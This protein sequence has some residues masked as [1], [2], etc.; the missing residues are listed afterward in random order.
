MIL[1][2]QHVHATDADDYQQDAR[3]NVRVLKRP[4]VEQ[5]TGIS[6]SLIYELVKAGTFPRPVKLTPNRVGWLEHEVFA[7]VQARAA[8]RQAA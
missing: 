8:R 5:V 3:Q 4:A 1:N 2:T 6:R 7:W